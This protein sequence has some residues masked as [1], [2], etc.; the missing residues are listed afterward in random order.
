MNQLY[1]VL[2][3]V[4]KDVYPVVARA[5]REQACVRWSV[6][7]ARVPATAMMLCQMGVP[8]RFF[9]APDHVSPA[10]FEVDYREDCDASAGEVRA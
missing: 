5:H 3:R 7:A 2:D 6:P 10:D 1:A 8:F 4:G 9:P